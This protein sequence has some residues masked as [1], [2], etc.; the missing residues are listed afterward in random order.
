MLL[1]RYFCLQYL[2]S[3]NFNLFCGKLTF[4]LNVKSK[5]LP[6]GEVAESAKFPVQLL[7][8]SANLSGEQNDTVI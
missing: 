8:I 4:L 7:P 5:S 1:V 3:Y 2:P 6:G